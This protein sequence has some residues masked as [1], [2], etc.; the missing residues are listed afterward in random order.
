M[1]MRTVV[2]AACLLVL[3]PVSAAAQVGGGV[4]GGL[5]LGDVPN[6][7]DSFD[8]AGLSSGQ[9]MG[10]AAGGFLTISLGSGFMIQPEVLYTQKGKKFDVGADGSS[11]IFKFEADYVDVPILARLTFG[12]V[13]RGYV[14][15]GPSMDFKLSA[16]MTTAIVGESEEE[17]DISDEIEN[18]EFAMVF[19][20]GVEF[21]PLLLEARWSE[22]LTN[23]A[24]DADAP[25]LKSRT[26]LFLAGLRF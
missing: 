15:A 7:A 11:G 16:K 18:F 25:D 10:F 19:G 22:G 1:S 24:K 6:W 21:G 5:T 20:G 3:L 12:K 2:V 9:R 17:E 4:K 13:V 26:F 23:L 14:F 8:E